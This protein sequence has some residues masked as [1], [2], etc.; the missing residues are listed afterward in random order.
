MFVV[1]CIYLFVVRMCHDEKYRF[2][3]RLCLIMFQ[4]I[5]LECILIAALPHRP[6]G[7]GRAPTSQ[8]E[9]PAQGAGWRAQ[10]HCLLDPVPD[11]ARH[12]QR[13]VQLHCA[14]RGRPQLLP[15][16]TR[17]P[18]PVCRRIYLH[19]EGVPPHRAC[20]V[21]RIA[22][23]IAS[24]LHPTCHSASLQSL[25]CLWRALEHGGLVFSL[26]YGEVLLWCWSLAV[27]LYSLKAHPSVA[28]GIPRAFVTYVLN[29]K[30]AATSPSSEDAVGDD[31]PEFDLAWLRA[32]VTGTLKT[33]A[34][35]FASGYLLQSALAL[36]GS[37]FGGKWSIKH[38]AAVLYG[39]SHVR[40]GLFF[41]AMAL[42]HWVT[43][44]TL[45]YARGTDDA[46]NHA[47]AGFAA[48]LPFAFLRSD[49][50]CA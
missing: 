46:M 35:A 50:I 39:K 2:D 48:G 5:A 1:V 32:A 17:H 43:R 44:H 4:A 21:L 13:H 31:E 29:L 3:T 47:V 28:K 19:R 41:G 9:R 30:P 33:T 37:V 26:P 16:P 6:R 20:R 49:R 42:L 34:R 10:E 12:A 18:R 24:S 23:P 14:A 45:H 8:A 22:G 40:T 15:H 38:L 27:L 11:V 25:W 36:A 7:P